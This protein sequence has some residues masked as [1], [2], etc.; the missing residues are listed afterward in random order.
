MLTNTLI[1]GN[2][3]SG[4]STLAKGLA[5]TYGVAH[6]DLD[7]I[8]WQPQSP[9]AR[10]PMA[11]SKA[12]IDAFVNTHTHW[13]IE[14]CY[15]DLLA[16]VTPLASNVLFL[17]LSA[18]D[19]IQNAKN[20]PWEPHKYESKEAQDANLDMLIHWISQ[21]TE[22]TDTFSKAAHEHLFNNF[23]GNKR[24]FESNQAKSRWLS[25]Q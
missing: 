25:Q 21:Y 9:P 19:C 6:L 2:S 16:L 5:N 10:M 24:M 18:N 7:T 12:L 20:R 3:A 22:R 17:N 8:A 14:G 4:K 11:E 13:V 23:E 15:S 1:F